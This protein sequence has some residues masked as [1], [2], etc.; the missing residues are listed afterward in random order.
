MEKI[1]D[2]LQDAVNEFTPYYS[3]IGSISLLGD[4]GDR[5]IG[6]TPLGDGSNLNQILSVSLL[7]AACLSS[8]Y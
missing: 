8:I 7:S 5:D 1:Q 6:S 2:F 3:Q 4:E